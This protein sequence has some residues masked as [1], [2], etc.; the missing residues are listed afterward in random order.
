MCPE[1]RSALDPHQGQPVANG[2]PLNDPAVLKRQNLGQRVLGQ[3]HQIRLPPPCRS[4]PLHLALPT[5]GSA[6]SCLPI[7]RR[8][9]RVRRLGITDQGSIL[10]VK[11]LWRRRWF[12]HAV[13]VARTSAAGGTSGDD[14]ADTLRPVQR[15]A[16]PHEIQG[17]ASARG[18]RAGL[19][20]LHQGNPDNAIRRRTE[21]VGIR[22]T[23]GLGP[24]MAA[25]VFAGERAETVR[26]GVRERPCRRCQCP[27]RP[28]RSRMPSAWQA[29]QVASEDTNGGNADAG[30]PPVGSRAGSSANPPPH[31]ATTAHGWRDRAPEWEGCTAPTRRSCGSC[32]D[33]RAARA[34]R[35]PDIPSVCGFRR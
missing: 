33:L 22:V 14:P 19:R 6:D 28:L 1:T 15:A 23:G 12:D 11:V 16:L 31:V 7:G 25:E 30:L 27:R 20:S 4:I 2:L 17:S 18:S 35:S 13:L 24:H 8:L 10:V 26:G 29:S 3:R 5:K 21:A 9:W 34:H 32:E